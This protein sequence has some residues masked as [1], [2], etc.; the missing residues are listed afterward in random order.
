MGEQKKKGQSRSQKAWVVT[1]NMGYGHERAASALRSIATKGEIIVANDYKGIPKSDD[2]IWKN[3]K[4]FYETISR[5]KPVPGVGDLAFE[6]MDKLQEIKPFYPDRD[7]S[8][9]TVQLKQMYRLIRKKK[10]GKHLI[11]MLRDRPLPFVTPFFLTAFFA[12]EHGYPGDIYVV[13]CDA[14]ISRTWAALDPHKS[15]IKYFA[16][17][18]RVVERLQQYGVPKKNIY[19]TGFPMPKE[20]IG[21]AK[22]PQA[23]KDLMS[24]L[25]NLDPNHYFINRYKKTIS[26]H[27]G[28]T[29]HTPKSHGPLTLTFAV[30]GA[31]AQKKLGMV[32]AKSLHVAMQRK[33]IRLQLVAGARP[34]VAAFFQKELRSAGY[35]K[36]LKSGGIKILVEK[37]RREY[38]DSFPEII[39]STDILWT[40]PSELS[41]YT[42][43]GVPIIMAPPIGSQEEFNRYW[44]T[45]V[46]GGINQLDPRYTAEW[47]FDWIE[48][49]GLARMAWNGFTEAPTHGAYR[50]EEVIT[51]EDV[52]LRKLPFIV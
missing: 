43:L 7:L 4:K 46:G 6:V 17:N 25:H 20:N 24:R 14:D 40:K 5:L 28:S 27:L 50:I 9:P 34:E 49:G 18:G 48:S 8:K 33:K 2:A 31:G 30:G 39:A 21:G 12:E 32:I 19:L 16:P 26:D 42:G 47:L 29:R 44:L 22:A 15:R 51:G 38:F 36:L 35:S 3:S 37:T 45:Q 23:K 13:V 11:D 1:V 10:Y 41:F 52:E